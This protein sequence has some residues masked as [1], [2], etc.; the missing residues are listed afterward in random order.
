MEDYHIKKIKKLVE[1]E[2]GY[3]IDSPTRKREVVEARGMY[4]TILKE[5]SSLSLAAIART[6][7][8]NH[9]TILHGLKNFKQ[10]R[11]ENKYLDLAYRNVVDK[12]SLLDEV[13]SFNDIKELR[14]ELV[15][16]KLENQNLKNIEQKKD[17]IEELLKD[18]PM[19]KVQEVKDRVKIMIQSYSWK[20]KDKVKVYQA[21][22]TVL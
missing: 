4:Y 8:K 12:L 6:V 22:A 5:F 21:N 14:K 9:A 3:F 17:S 13:E 1:Q 15:R 2:Y 20:Y 16:L 19:D 10:W 18:L 11:K 7:G